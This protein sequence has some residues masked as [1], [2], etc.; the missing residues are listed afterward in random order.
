MKARKLYEEAKLSGMF[1]EWYPELTWDWEKDRLKW[2]EM[3]GFIDKNSTMF[4]KLQAIYD[5]ETEEEIQAEW[6][7]S[8][9][10][11]STD[12]PTEKYIDGSTW[13]TSF[14]FSGPSFDTT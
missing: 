13:D 12:H 2:L 5:N 7:S 10:V 6:N 9:D 1:G 8:T 4:E 14:I 3:H 11:E